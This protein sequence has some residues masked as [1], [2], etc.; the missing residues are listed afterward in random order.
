M[1]LAE[2]DRHRR[3]IQTRNGPASVVD[4]GGDGRPVLFVHGLGTNAY[5]WRHVI[6]ELAGERRCVAVDLPSHGRTPATDDQDLSLPALADFVAG[7]C[8]ALDLDGF[9]LVANDTGGAVAQIVA[10]RNAGRLATLTLTDCDTQD[11]L[12]PKAFLPTVM[13][14][15][16]GVLARVGPRLMKD[17]RRARARVYGSGYEDVRNLPEEVARA[18]L[19]PLF[20]TPEA[21]RRFQRVITSLRARDLRAIGPDLARLRVPTLIVWGTADVFFSLKWAYWLRDTIPGAT[22]V[23]EVDGGKLFFPDERAA[24]LTG[25]LRRH[26]EAHP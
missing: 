2:L 5:L 21:A 14:A 12:P 16:A 7:C 8:D 23:V 13:L 3:E 4:T 11:N 18:F 9:D 22:E 6:G 19:E 17:P 15:R 24:E 26:W 10:V 25:A 1:T 20:G